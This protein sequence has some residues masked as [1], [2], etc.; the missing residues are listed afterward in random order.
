MVRSFHRIVR[1]F[2]K[3]V[4]SLPR[5]LS[6]CSQSVPL[7][8][9]K[10]KRF[11]MFSMFFYSVVTLADVRLNMKNVRRVFLLEK[12]EFRLIFNTSWIN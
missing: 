7:I 2:H 1:S 5:D 8:K 3:N 4:R 9:S 10:I 11:C 6:Q 12:A